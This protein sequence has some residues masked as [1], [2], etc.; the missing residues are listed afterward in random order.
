M[1]RNKPAGASRWQKTTDGSPTAAAWAA[2]ETPWFPV[3][4]AT[5][6]RFPSRRAMRDATAW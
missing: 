2:A 5:T 3:E 1:A 6:P 4:L